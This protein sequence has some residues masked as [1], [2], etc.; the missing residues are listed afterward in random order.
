LI[1]FVLI[2]YLNIISL[3]SIMKKS[4]FLAAFT[5]C[6]GSF[7][8]FTG[9]SDPNAPKTTQERI[10]E[11]ED[12]IRNSPEWLNQVKKKAEDNKVPLDTM[13]RKDATWMVDDQDGK[14]VPEAAPAAPAPEAAKPAGEAAPAP[15]PAAGH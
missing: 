4:F 9:C 1:I 14:H 3:F 7:I 5:L 15:A 6:I 10:S 13:I 8:T 12:Q 11:I 2:L